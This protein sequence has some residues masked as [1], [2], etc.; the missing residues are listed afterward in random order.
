MA[1]R[2]AVMT[3]TNGLSMM[4]PVLEVGDTGLAYVAVHAGV[5]AVATWNSTSTPGENAGDPAGVVAV[6]VLPPVFGP[7]VALSVSVAGVT[8]AQLGAAA[9]IRAAV[10]LRIAVVLKMVRINGPPPAG[11]TWCE[12]AGGR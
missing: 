2:F 12:L 1:S 5:A 6:M 7:V 3:I 9:P 10:I 4:P 8:A 11:T